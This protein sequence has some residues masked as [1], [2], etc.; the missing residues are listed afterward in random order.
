MLTPTRVVEITPAE[1]AHIKQ[2]QLVVASVLAIR[3]RPGPKARP[4]EC[5]Y[6]RPWPEQR[7]V[8]NREDKAALVRGFRRETRR[9]PDGSLA[10]TE[11]DPPP[12]SPRARGTAG[13]ARWVGKA[14]PTT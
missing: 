11:P 3:E 10:Q 9:I 1:A 6:S 2:R 5:K 14:C 4:P 8:E 12:A 13:L 7:R